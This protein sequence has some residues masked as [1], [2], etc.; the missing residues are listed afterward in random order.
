MLTHLLTKWSLLSRILLDNVRQSFLHGPASLTADTLDY[1][2]R[3]SFGLLGK[4][5]IEMGAEAAVIRF[6]KCLMNSCP[7]ERPESQCTP[8]HSRP[9]TKHP[10][11]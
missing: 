9:G 8:T 2:K 1:V 6:G 5:E 10:I 4:D 3:F 7:S 11:P